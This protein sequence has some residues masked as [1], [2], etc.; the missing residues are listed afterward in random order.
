MNDIFMIILSTIF[1]YWLFQG[2]FS[3]NN[4]KKLLNLNSWISIIVEGFI[5]VLLISIIL[6]LSS[7]TI[8]TMAPNE[9]DIPKFEVNV[10]TGQVNNSLTIKDST[11]NIPDVVAKGLTHLGTGAGI[12]AGLKGGASIA[13]ASGLSPAA[14]IGIMTGGAAIGGIGITVTNVA[15][16][17][18]QKRIDSIAVNSTKSNPISTSISPSS[19]NSNNG[20]GP[21]AF[22]I[23]PGADLDTVMT[24][25]NTNLIL[26]I[27]ILYLPIALMILYI[28]T[29]VFE[30][31]W[32]L[33]FIKNL[34]GER[35]YNLLIKSLS[36]S[37]KYNKVWMF[38]AWIF[39]IFGGIVG[40]YI[41]QIL[42]DNIDII[43]EIVK[44]SKNK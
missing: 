43:S 29:M 3:L 28:S 12:A 14:K 39:L 8:Y 17:F 18:L 13:K 15:N 44:E 22:S 35:F 16:S 7:D 4:I 10:T 25:L 42:I 36:Y 38:I 21:A 11:I 6:Y 23:E 33:T 24:L 2:Y 34:F 37:A 26:H 5:F 30:N 9:N 20:D 32:N 41:S 1:F 19:S 31:K 27:C 40:I